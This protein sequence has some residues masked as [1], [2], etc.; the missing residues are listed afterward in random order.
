MR[1][2]ESGPANC[3]KVNQVG[4]RRSRYGTQP[5][6]HVGKRGRYRLFIDAKV[7]KLQMKNKL[8]N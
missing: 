8:E 4:S 2:G 6:F 1:F 3:L 5:T 7:C